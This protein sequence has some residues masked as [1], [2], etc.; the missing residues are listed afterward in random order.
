MSAASDRARDAYLRRTYGLSLAQFLKMMLKQGRKCAICERHFSKYRA[1]VD[2]AHKNRPD[3]GRVRGILCYL[4][5]KRLL[6]RGNENPT[7]HE[8]AA[9]YLTS[10]FDGRNI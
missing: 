4:C 9:A 10:A 7:L 2:H 5:N 8:R 6:G 1:F 3:A